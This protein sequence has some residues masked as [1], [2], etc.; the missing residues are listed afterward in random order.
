MARPKKEEEAD[1]SGSQNFLNSLLN[2]YSDDHYNR[3]ESTPVAISSGSLILDSH[4]KVKSGSSIRICSET[5]ESGK[6]SQ[7]FLFASNFMQVMKKSKVIYIKA[8]SRLSPE[9]MKRAGLKFVLNAEEWKDGTVFVFEC[10]FFETI[11][12]TLKGLLKVCHE[13]GE[14]LCIIIDSLDGLMLKRDSEKTFSSSERP[15]VAGV[16]YLTKLLFRHIGL[17]INKYNSLLILVSQYSSTIKLDPYAKG[18]RK[19][20]ESS[21]GNSISFQSDYI[22]NYLPRYNGDMILEKEKERP[23]PTSNRI[24][25]VFANIELK[26]SATDN[27]GYRLSIPIKKGRIGNAVW[28]EKEVADLILSWDLA[29]R[30]GAWISFSENVI[31]EAKDNNLELK[32]KVQGLNGLYEYLEANKPIANWFLEKFKSM[33]SQS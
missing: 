31:K 27:S 18:E 22:L 8:E 29:K 3:I 17:A 15:V 13:N 26:K 21:G 1:T 14:H 7:S 33:L 10:N 25:G 6:T 11:A 2:G 24:L 32:E 20:V 4:I 9:M 12:D 5:P 23:D 28:I 30:A 19:V 16:A